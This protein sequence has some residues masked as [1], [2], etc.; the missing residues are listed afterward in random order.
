MARIS[1][2]G[3]GVPWAS[4]VSVSSGAGPADVAAQHEQIGPGVRT[5]GRV[6]E[7]LA[8]RRLQDVDVV[9]DFAQ[10]PHPPAVGLEPLHGVVVIGQ[11][12]RAVD[13]DVVVVVDGEQAAQ[14]EMPGQRCRLVGDAFHDAAVAGQHENAV[15]A[16][17]G[18]EAGPHHALGEGHAD[19]V[20]EALP[21]RAGGDLDARGVPELG[22]ARRPAVPLPEPA[23]V[24]ERQVVAGQVQEGVLEDGGV[25][26]REDE[27]V[28]VGPRRVERVVVHDARPEHV[29]QGGQ[30]HGRAR[31]AGARLPRRVHGQPAHDVDA[32]LHQPRV[33]RRPGPAARWH[34]THSRYGHSPFLTGDRPRR[35][36]RHLCRRC[37][38]HVARPRVCLSSG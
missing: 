25:P 26:A 15:V 16:H 23:Q 35:C 32:E 38:C 6:F 3:K 20:G 4:A 18:P 11:L 36:R 5:V 13:G 29:R 22:V 28:A 24:I 9:G 27:A 8:H 34:P 33:L 21:Q 14:A 2:G 17:L 12:G 31:M 30:G 37:L 1:S 7:R 19:R 10:V